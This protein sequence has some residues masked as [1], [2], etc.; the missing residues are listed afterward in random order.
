LLEKDEEVVLISGEM[1]KD[2]ERE[3]ERARESVVRF[4][5][6]E[7]KIWEFRGEKQRIGLR[8]REIVSEREGERAELNLGILGRETKWSKGDRRPIRRYL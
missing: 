3:R 8:Q 1:G 4:L 7:T 2:R 6:R 5:G